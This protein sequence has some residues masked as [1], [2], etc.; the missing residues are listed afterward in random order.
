M[1]LT[2]LEKDLVGTLLCF[3]YKLSKLINSAIDLWHN[4]NQTKNESIIRNRLC[5]L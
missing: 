4:L 5:H 1:E 2:A 3:V